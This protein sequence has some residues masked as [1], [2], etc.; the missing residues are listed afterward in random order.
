MNFM[1]NASGIIRIKTSGDLPVN[2]GN[3][4]VADE[5]RIKVVKY[6]SGN[7]KVEILSGIYAG[8]GNNRIP[9]N[10]IKLYKE[11]GNLLLDFDTDHI[12]KKLNLRTEVLK[13]K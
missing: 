13:M 8:N 1:K 2:F 9:M 6:E 5:A 4:Q 11:D 3:I 12:H 10:S 7:L